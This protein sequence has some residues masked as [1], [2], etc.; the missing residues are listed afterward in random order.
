MNLDT[1]IILFIALLGVIDANCHRY[2]GKYLI[3]IL[4]KE[5]RH[6]S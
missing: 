2:T 5:R 6:V 1:I 3:E 4:F